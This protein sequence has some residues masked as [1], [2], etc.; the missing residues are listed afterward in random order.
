MRDLFYRMCSI[1]FGLLC[2][3]L[4]IMSFLIVFLM[5][6]GKIQGSLGPAALLV[7]QLSVWLMFHIVPERVR[8]HLTKN[9][10]AFISI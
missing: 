9:P 10:P 8:L 7:A 4:R 6:I 5:L 2:A 1:R 3:L